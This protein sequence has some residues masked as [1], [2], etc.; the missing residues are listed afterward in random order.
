MASGVSIRSKYMNII[1]EFIEHYKKEYDF[2]DTASKLVAQQL[3]NALHTSGIRAIVTY[4]A[5]NPQRLY[6]KLIQRDIEHHYSCIEDI[7]NDIC[8]F[9]GVR[10]A[11]YFPSDRDNVE[12]IIKDTFNLLQEPKIFPTSQKITNFNK[13]FSG[14]W[15]RHYRIS[16]KDTSLTEN[17]LRYVNSKTEI[18]VASVLMHAWSEVEHDLVYKPLSG[19]LSNEELSIL[20]E[21]NGLVLAGEIALE[22]LNEAAKN[23]IKNEK[24]FNNQYELASFLYIKYQNKIESN[25]Q[26]KLGNVELLFNL[27]VRCEILTASDITPYLKSLDFTKDLRTISEIITDNI[28]YGNPDRYNI[29]ISLKTSSTEENTELHTAIGKFMEQWILLE[30]LINSISMN[31]NPNYRT[32]FSANNLKLIFSPVEFSHIMELRKYRNALVHGMLAPTISNLK[33]MTDEIKMICD[34]LQGKLS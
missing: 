8:D 13:R 27:M 23:R 22:R 5:K 7:Y 26:I 34:K 28:I 12:E 6:T 4:R 18:Q 25:K 14:Y 32:P 29:Y 31:K 11:L 20:D 24:A 21:L 19:N 16:L 9:S 30:R 2:Y 3:E 33:Q 1:D 10:V 15:A 17:Q